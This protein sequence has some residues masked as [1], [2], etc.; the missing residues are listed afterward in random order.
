MS[1]PTCPTS[2]RCSLSS[3]CT[4]IFHIIIIVFPILSYCFGFCSLFTYDI[5]LSHRLMHFFPFHPPAVF[6]GN[7]FTVG[8]RSY[9]HFVCCAC[10]YYWLLV[11][12]IWKNKLSMNLNLNHILKELETA[13]L[14]PSIWKKSTQYETKYDFS[15]IFLFQLLRKNTIE[16][17]QIRTSFDGAPRRRVGKSEIIDAGF[18][19]P[20][21][22][23]MLYSISKIGTYCFVLNATTY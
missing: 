3:Y 18:S 13:I 23:I 21:R 15:K 11:L 8:G 16:R 10:F 4:G 19:S 12:Y 7:R 20:L 2:S 5:I 9:I 17:R 6:S 14:M 1:H 22:Y